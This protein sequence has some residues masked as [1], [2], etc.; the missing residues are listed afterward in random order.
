[1]T[2]RE[3]C[4]MAW[5]SCEELPWS[6]GPKLENLGLRSVDQNLDFVYSHGDM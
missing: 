2:R 5:I 3:L 6:G 1:M 4:D